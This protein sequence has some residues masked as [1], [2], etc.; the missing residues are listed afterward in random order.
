MVTGNTPV[1]ISIILFP[2]RLKMNENRRGVK[3]WMGF[4]QKAVPVSNGLQHHLL[5]LKRGIFF[6]RMDDPDVLIPFYN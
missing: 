3:L 6:L 5:G 1:L 4:I 2:M